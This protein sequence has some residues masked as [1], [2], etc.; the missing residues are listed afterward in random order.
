MA[1][2]PSKREMLLRL[3]DRGVT[4]RVF[5][6]KGFA[7]LQLEVE[8][9]YKG[10]KPRKERKSF[11]HEDVAL[12][13]QDAAEV[14]TRLL[15]SVP[16]P[17]GPNSALT[18]KE[19]VERYLESAAFR[20]T[21]TRTME[22]RKSVLQWITGFQDWATKPAIH[23]SQEDVLEYFQ[24]R[25]RG[26]YRRTPASENVGRRRAQAELQM[27]RTALN[28]AYGVR[29]QGK[30]LIS[31]KVFDGLVLPGG[32]TPSQPSVNANTFL[33]L[34]GI[35]HLMHPAFASALALAAAYGKRGE[36]IRHLRWTDINW[37]DHLVFWNPEHDKEEEAGTFW[38]PPDIEAILEDW[39]LH[40]ERPDSPFVFAAPRKPS[41]P[42]SRVS[43]GQWMGRA[44]KKAELTKPRQG[45]WHGLR[46]WFSTRNTGGDEKAAMRVAGMKNTSTFFR[47][48]QP[49]D[50]ALK[51]VL[52]NRPLLT[53]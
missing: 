24:A 46:R 7:P 25:T 18:L 44:Y 42:I 35:R 23:L 29:L 16:E 32:G 10:A 20:A 38:L 34:W 53:K 48:Q 30:R 28:W 9:R 51:R 2:K 13:K 11:G 45:G 50:A 6:R 36:S 19:T 39:Y 31:E 47:Y 40:P 37:G 26:H 14:F 12:A 1:S 15:R 17:R 8:E 33:A 41:E 52:Q 4:V 21:K 27:L 49:D 3:S 43:F 5:R 22:D